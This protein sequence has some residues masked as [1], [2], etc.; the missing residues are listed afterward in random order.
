MTYSLWPVPRDEPND[1]HPKRSAVHPNRGPGRRRRTLVAIAALVLALVGVAIWQAVAPSPSA[2]ASHLVGPS[3]QPAPAFSLPSLRAPR[4]SLTL[5]SFRGRPVVVNFW[6]SWC[7]P[8]RTEMT[9]LEQAYQAHHGRVV[10]IGVDTHD[11][12]GAARAFL[13][14]VHVTYPTLSDVDG[15]TALSY[16][17][18]G[19]PTTIFISSNGTE[20][21]RHIGQLD[22]NS[23][24]A[25]LKEAFHV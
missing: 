20:L 14:Q 21:G 19:L 10:F 24:Q 15:Q 12:P 5:A 7:V 16:A 25:G 17:L 4:S 6:A 18:F 2:I 11:T 1:A 3:G 8:C 13:A 22:S 23:L 9:L